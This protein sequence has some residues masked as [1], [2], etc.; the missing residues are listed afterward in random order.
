CSSDLENG[1]YPYSP[2]GKIFDEL[3][4]SY[5]EKGKTY[6]IFSMNKKDIEEAGECGYRSI[7]ILLG[8]LGEFKGKVLSY[9]GPFGVGYGVMSFKNMKDENI[10]NRSEEHT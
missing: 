4:L 3:I 10:L 7:L 9:E 2:K 6:E 1:P 5:L 8:V